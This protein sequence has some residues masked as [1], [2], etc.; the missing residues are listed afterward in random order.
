MSRRD[1]ISLS[2]AEMQEFLSSSKTVILCSNGKDGY[3][4]VMPMWFRLAEDGAIHMT[5]YARSQKVLNLKR[6]PRATLLVESGIGYAELK[7]VMFRGQVEIIEDLD[8]IVDTMMSASN[9]RQP[10]TDPEQLAS[11]R[12]AMKKTASK[13]VL[14][15]IQP[16][17][18]ISWDHSKLGGVY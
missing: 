7:G 13:R 10:V 14:L 16:E 3:P 1:Q 2:D 11:L 17:V 15:R 6:D 18:A 12:E 5:T 9:E 4:H 8:Q